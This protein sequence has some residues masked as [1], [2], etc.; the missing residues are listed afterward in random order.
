MPDRS[1]HDPPMADIRLFRRIVA[2]RLVRVGIWPAFVCI[3]SI[4][5]S[6]PGGA[7]DPS[8]MSAPVFSWGVTGAVT[9]RNGEPLSVALVQ[10]LVYASAG[11]FAAIANT[12]SFGRF[13][14]AT[15]APAGNGE[16]RVSRN[17]YLNQVASFTCVP[18]VPGA[19]LCGD[20][21]SIIVNVTL[22]QIVSA[23]VTSPTSL[24]VDETM[25][26][27]R[28]IQLDDGRTIT[29]NGFNPALSS[30]DIVYTNDPAIVMIVAG[31]SAGKM[32]RGVAEG[33]TNIVTRLAS[34]YGFT[35]VTVSF[36]K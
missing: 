31:T 6:G 16:L 21:N 3:L 18:P 36:A 15:T 9:N 22:T 1:P 5:C 17:G 23:V 2:I 12:D 34:V 28:V 27:T 24:S 14:L 29:D 4:G 13:S 26:I 30:D 10:L 19:R 7:A 8:P 35:P 33:N 25:P 32:V 20:Q 11:K